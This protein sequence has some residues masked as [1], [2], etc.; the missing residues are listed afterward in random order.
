M[1]APDQVRPVRSS[2]AVEPG[3]DGT[4]RLTKPAAIGARAAVAAP[5]ALPERG[6]LQL[7]AQVRCGD[8]WRR[9]AV[10]IVE[11]LDPRGQVVGR[12]QTTPLFRNRAWTRVE[13]V[14]PK[15]AGAVRGRWLLALRGRAG[16]R[17]QRGWAEFRAVALRAVP[18]VV[19]DTP[20]FGVVTEGEA[21][22]I[23]VESPTAGDGARFHGDLVDVTGQSIQAWTQGADRE[24]HSFDALAPGYYELRWRLENGDAQL[25]R[26]GRRA[27]TVLDRAPRP[28]TSPF[29]V[30]AGL[31]WGVIQRGEAT[32]AL[33]ASWLAQAGLHH[34]RDRLGLGEVWRDR[35][36][37]DLG[38]YARAAEVQAAAGLEVCQMVS[39]LAPWMA[40]ESGVRSGWRGPAAD[41]RDVHAAFQRMARGL[42]DTVPAIE[43]WNE[44]DIRFFAGR[45]EEYAAILKAAYLG[46]KKGNPDTTA[47]IGAPFQRVTAWLRAVY[48]C[49][50][51]DYYD[52]FNF[53]CYRPAA[54]LPDDVTAFT[55]LQQEYG[56]DAPLWCTET[57]DGALA[58]GPGA[59]PLERRQAA[60][61][62]QRC[63]LAAAAGVERVF[64]FYLQEHRQ[65]GEGA[66]GL[67]RPDLTPRPGLAALAAM[68]RWLG[69]ARP[70][71]R[72]PRAQRGVTVLW[73]ER[74]EGA[75]TA[76]LWAQHDADWPRFFGAAATVRDL[77]GRPIAP[78]E[79]LSREPAYVLGAQPPTDLLTGPPKR[80]ARR[81]GAAEL[82]PLQVVLDL[83]LRPE[84]DTLLGQPLRKGAA[85]VAAKG[86]L[87][88]DVNVYNFG[89]EPARIELELDLPDG[90]SGPSPTSPID[91][92]PGE[93]DTQ[94][95]AFRVGAARRRDQV[96]RVT[97]RSP[98]FRIAPAA[99]RVRTIAP[100]P[101]LRSVDRLDAGEGI[102]SQ[103]HGTTAEA[104]AELTLDAK[105]AAPL[106]Q[107]VGLRFVAQAAE[108][109]LD[110]VVTVTERDGSRYR[111]RPRRIGT[112]ATTVTLLWRELAGVA[113]SP[114]ENA[115]LNPAQMQ[116]IAFSAPAEF[117]VSRVESCGR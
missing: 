5:F 93:R 96:V 50:A 45:P 69:T 97:A 72:D 13:A 30:D 67:L 90:W 68:T 49:G 78:P 102:T 33:I 40:E 87:R 85:I 98:D 112:A 11:M 35:T 59:L 80:R 36:T 113:G 7:E 100:P 16:D 22:T 109:P 89:D 73:F 115:L 9:D 107:T 1:L 74:A 28:A 56:V 31:S 25:V 62:V 58:L 63:A 42:A 10:I 54:T 34:V 55:A 81:R 77:M 53:H 18:R 61:Y 75:P 2:V 14:G 12:L 65:P 38:R 37:F 84:R 8:L 21:L 79:S 24:D 99:A 23:G 19:I 71:G 44:Q 60:L 52:V 46:I 104:F 86:Q 4:I 64:P 43:I 76:V 88:A 48:E 26:R 3:D 41:L 6:P 111:G 105:Q 70:L 101:P 116:S 92:A 57:G 51:A 39:D 47:L 83:R 17:D 110:V 29:G 103:R 91:L 20:R 32:A 106:A 108:S 94:S 27:L 66:F 82:A 114:D 95:L 15:A 117:A